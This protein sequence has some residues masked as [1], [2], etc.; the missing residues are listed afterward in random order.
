MYVW[1]GSVRQDVTRPVTE[2]NWY[3][4]TSDP[5]E[6]VTPQGRDSDEHYHFTHSGSCSVLSFSSSKY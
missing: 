4:T 2:R 6:A 1:K 5:C 3:T